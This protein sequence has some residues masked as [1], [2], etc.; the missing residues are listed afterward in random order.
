MVFGI[1]AKFCANSFSFEIY[2][3]LLCKNNGYKN[4]DIRIC[5]NLRLKKTIELLRKFVS[6]V[7]RKFSPKEKFKARILVRVKS[8]KNNNDGLWGPYLTKIEIIIERMLVGPKNEWV[9]M[10]SPR[11]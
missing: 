6:L 8:I 11:L 3:F 5:S 9:T 7:K 4:V 1:L 10:K 2:N